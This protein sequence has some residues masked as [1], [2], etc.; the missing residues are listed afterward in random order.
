[1]D[2]G[3]LSTKTHASAPI[4]K[5]VI[6]RKLLNQAYQNRKSR[7]L[8]IGLIKICVANF[9]KYTYFDANIRNTPYNQVIKLDTVLAALELVKD[10][11]YIQ[12]N[13]NGKRAFT[14][15]KKNVEPF[16]ILEVNANTTHG[17]PNDTA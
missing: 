5:L 1:M 7:T 9:D 6:E 3:K 4:S 8:H 2:Q 17:P 14:E 15:D 13:K 16:M 10:N 12:V 11:C